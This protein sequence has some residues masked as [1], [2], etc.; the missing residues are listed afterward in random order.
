MPHHTMKRCPLFILFVTVLCVLSGHAD[1]LPFCMVRHYDDTDGL[2]QRAVKQIVQDSN[3]FIWIATW[4]GLH[5]FDGY[6]FSKIKPDDNDDA[7][8]YSNRIGDLKLSGDDGL[9]C[10]VDDHLLRFNLSTYRFEDISS[11][12]ENK[13]RTTFRI[14]QILTTTDGKT[15]V[16]CDD[17]RYITMTDENPVGS[18]TLSESCPPLKFI[19]SG[20]RKLGDIGGYRNDELVYSQRHHDG[21]LWIVTRNGEVAYSDGTTEHFI[22]VGR[23]DTGNSP[24]FYSMTDSSGNVWLRNSNGAYRLTLGKHNYEKLPSQTRTGTRMRTAAIAP[25]GSL[26]VSESDRNA[27]AVYPTLPDGSP[28]HSHPLYLGADGRLHKEFTQFGVPVYAVTFTSGPTV[29]LGSKPGGLYRVRRKSDGEY[30]VENFTHNPSDSRSISSANV[31]DIAFDRKGRLWVATLGGG[32]DCS[33]NPDDDTPTFTRLASTEA[34]PNGAQR[35]RRLHISGDSLILAA[36]TGGLLTARLPQRLT[37][38]RPTLHISHPGRGNSLG[39]IAVMDAVTDRDGNIFVATESDGINMLKAPFNPDDPYP[40]FTR[41]NTRAG[42]PTDIT[43]SEATTDDG[44]LLV[45]SNNLLYTLNPTDSS[46]TAYKSSYW[47]DNLHFTD[48]RPIRLGN[49]K[50]LIGVEDGAIVCDLSTPETTDRKTPLIF[51]SVSIQN[52]PDSLLS[53]SSDTVMLGSHERNLTLRFAALDFTAP[54]EIL[55]YFRLD[56]GAWTPIGRTRSVTF[57]D[58]DPGTYR[59]EIKST[60]SYGKQTDET[61]TM[62]I[63]VTPTFWE[64]PLAYFLYVL[65]S[66]GIIATAVYTLLYIRRIKRKQR[67][68]L[69]AYLRLLDATPSPDKSSDSPDDETVPNVSDVPRKPSPAVPQLSPA[70]EAFMNRVVEFVNAHLNDPGITVDDMASAVAT[71]RSGLNRKMK[72]ILGVTPGD[73]IRE[74]RLSRASTLLAT[75]DRPVKDIA[76]DCGFSDLNYFGKCFK[77]AYNLTPTAYRK[78]QS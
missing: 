14:S 54:A 31:H 11:L 49:G 66:A 68:T 32:I 16:R 9:W 5:R 65:L 40:S 45:T 59:L 47:H 20:N 77:S 19:S 3:G 61:T 63:I 37:D 48:A 60:D 1:G 42:L 64:T 24:L 34:Y 7:R 70:D 58:M 21:S 78:A 56:N 36:T 53:A 67:E 35:V 43:L 41:F 72:S 13:F 17:N 25:D 44:H 26:W 39:N 76:F 69:E 74:S 23:L 8:R 50:W 75:T 55:Y 22:T 27:I 30:N 6:E 33:E 18:A 51:T 12:L 62:T 4:D 57:L 10:R 73:F 46:A 52:R 29:W 2:S 38:F 28:A 15:V 71:S